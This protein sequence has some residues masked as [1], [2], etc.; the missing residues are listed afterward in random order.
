MFTT[1]ATEHW[2]VTSSAK[3]WKVRI[4]EGFPISK[5]SKISKIYICE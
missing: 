3:S 5:E 2:L 1:A 4:L